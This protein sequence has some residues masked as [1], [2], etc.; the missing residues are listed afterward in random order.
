MEETNIDIAYKIYNHLI[1][2]GLLIS[3]IKKI[4]PIII[5]KYIFKKFK[6]F[7][8]LYFNIIFFY[9]KND[10]N[11]KKLKIHLKYRNL[12]L[13]GNKNELNLRLIENIKLIY[14]EYIH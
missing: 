2:L 4:E 10:F 14:N 13:K 7:Y 12:S 8:P 3:D 6:E 1:I 5:L 11:I 9:D